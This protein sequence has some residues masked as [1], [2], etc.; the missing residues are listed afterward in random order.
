LTKNN[1][2]RKKRNFEK[3]FEKNQ[4]IN[5]EHLKS[6]KKSKVVNNMITKRH[7]KLKKLKT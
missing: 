1:S 6:L 5:F 2:E 7:T 4:R 3:S